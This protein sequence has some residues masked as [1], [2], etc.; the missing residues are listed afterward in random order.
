[1]CWFCLL[2]CY[3]RRC[4]FVFFLVLC[5]FSFFL[6][7]FFHLSPLF[8]PAVPPLCR[9]SGLFSPVNVQPCART[10]AFG[11]V[12]PL[13]LLAFIQLLNAAIVLLPAW[14]RLRDR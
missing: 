4:M 7:I 3:F 10:V 8:S 2:Q 14:S 1:M 13:L 12:L 5:S 11:S 6:L 9:A